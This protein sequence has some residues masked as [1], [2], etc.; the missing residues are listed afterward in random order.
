MDGAFSGFSPVVHI[1]TDKN[2]AQDGEIY[3]FNNLEIYTK[4]EQ[5]NKT[6][7]NVTMQNNYTS[8]SRELK[9]DEYDM[10]KFGHYVQRGSVS[11]NYGA[12]RVDLDV[13]GE[14]SEKTENNEY[15]YRTLN[16]IQRY[17]N[18]GTGSKAFKRL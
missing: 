7:K 17:G 9:I 14:I 8:L 2:I 1:Q 5:R 3:N 15:F 16:V 6:I 11:T 10:K 13:K 18:Y 12:E 4:D